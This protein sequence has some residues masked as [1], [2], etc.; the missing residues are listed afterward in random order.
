M[1]LALALVTVLPAIPF[2]LSLWLTLR[3][4]PR[5]KPVCLMS[6]A[7][8][9][10]LFAGLDADGSGSLDGEELGALLKTIGAVAFTHP[11]GFCF[12]V[13]SYSTNQRA[14]N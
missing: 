4:P 9:W 2:G 12:G 1:Y 7:E 11:L 8:L 6:P 3:E 14:N 10:E 5:P 13:N